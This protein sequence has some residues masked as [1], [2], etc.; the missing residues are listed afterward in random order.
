MLDSKPKAISNCNLYFMR[1][2]ILLW[3]CDD[4]SNLYVVEDRN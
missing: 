4:W 3:L 2:K 1:D